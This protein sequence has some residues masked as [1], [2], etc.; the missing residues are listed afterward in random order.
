M[1]NKILLFKNRSSVDAW[2]VQIY[3]EQ[4]K[5]KPHSVLG[6]AT[7]TTPINFYKMLQEDHQKNGTDWSKIV[8][9]NLDEFVGIPIGHKESFRTQMENNLYN[10]LNINIKNTHLPDGMCID[11]SQEANNYEKLIKSKGGIDLQ[12]ITLGVNGHMAYNEPGTSLKTKTHVTGLTPATREEIVRQGKFRTLEET[13]TAAIT[14]G[15]KTIMNCK[16][17][18]MVIVGD[19]KATMAKKALEETPTAEIPASQLQKHKKCLFVMDEDSAKLL[20]LTKHDVKR[21]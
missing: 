7:G 1:K 17:V 19:N 20:D 12:F 21:M 5:T 2:L 18:L 9:F 16:K 11:L 15:V 14:M 6:F 3:K 13:P 10:G 4:I 8:A